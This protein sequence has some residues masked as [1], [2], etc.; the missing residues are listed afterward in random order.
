MAEGIALLH[1]RMGFTNVATCTL[2]RIHSPQHSTADVVGP[3][4]VHGYECS[5]CT[6]NDDWKTRLVYVVDFVVQGIKAYATELSFTG[7]MYKRIQ[8][9]GLFF[10]PS[11]PFSSGPSKYMSWKYFLIIWDF[12]GDCL[13]VKVCTLEVLFRKFCTIKFST[14]FTR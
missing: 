12:I 10:G 6:N 3:T 8:Q 14:I 13:D 1:A 4:P 2:R 9:I 7:N 5:F 11:F